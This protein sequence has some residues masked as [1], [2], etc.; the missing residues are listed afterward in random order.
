MTRNE[1]VVQFLVRLDTRPHA[2]T[3]LK[4]LRLFRWATGAKGRVRL[5]MLD[6]EGW[7][8]VDYPD[9][10]RAGGAGGADDFETVDAA[11]ARA[12]LAEWDAP[13]DVLFQGLEV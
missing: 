11:R 1:W 8:W 9:L 12:L 10:L 6:P 3:Y 2:P 4:P 13:G 7:S 5:E